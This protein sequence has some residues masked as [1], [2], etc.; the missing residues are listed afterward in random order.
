MT[1]NKTDI[2]ALKEA[3]GE[4]NNHDLYN[5]AD[6]INC[7]IQLLMTCCKNQTSAAY[8]AQ[9][10]VQAFFN[11]VYRVEQLRQDVA[12]AYAN[13][14]KTQLD[15]LCRQAENCEENKA[16]EMVWSDL[17]RSYDAFIS[18]LDLDHMPDNKIKTAGEIE[19]AR[20]NYKIVQDNKHMEEACKTAMWNLN[21]II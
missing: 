2:K 20:R 17:A 5:A 6:T 19:Q 4:E 14:N 1:T 10:F 18:T 8:I 15:Y 16:F 21:N 13:K 12:E 3:N 11:A 9:S 7:G